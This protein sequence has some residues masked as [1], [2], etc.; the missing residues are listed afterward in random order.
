MNKKFKSSLGIMS[1]EFVIGSFM[2]I[3]TK[4][5][6]KLLFNLYQVM[7]LMPFIGYDICCLGAPVDQNGGS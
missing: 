3:M 4:M 7:I 6:G 2:C 1:I 5:S